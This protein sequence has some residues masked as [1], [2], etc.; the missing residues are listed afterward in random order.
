MIEH[1]F[2][3]FKRCFLCTPSES[4]SKID[5]IR[6]FDFFFFGSIELFGNIFCI[7]SKSSQPHSE[8]EIEACYCNHPGVMHE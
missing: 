5:L 2:C 6:K 7:S 8:R 3:R 4:Q 1:V